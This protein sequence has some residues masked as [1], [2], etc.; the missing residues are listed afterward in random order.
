[1]KKRIGIGLIVIALGLVS[2]TTYGLISNNIQG[3]GHGLATTVEVNSLEETLDSYVNSV[4]KGR[5]IKT[6]DTI[7]EHEKQEKGPDFVWSRTPAIIQ[8]DEVLHGKNVGEEI[9]FYEHGKR[10]DSS[11]EFLEVG[12][13]VILFLDQETSYGGYWSYSFEDG[14]WRID[15]EGRVTSKGKAEING[16]LQNL[17]TKS[18]IQEINSAK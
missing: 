17:N 16:I 8:V 1:M 18:F 7:T 10:S 4:V 3:V 14:L 5:V 2:G 15:K 13:E 6:L 12:E 9:T 11:K